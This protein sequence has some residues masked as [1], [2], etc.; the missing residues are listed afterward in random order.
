MAKIVAVQRELEN[1]RKELSS[2]GYIVVDLKEGCSA[3]VI[4]YIWQDE[5]IPYMGIG[6]SL[7]IGLETGKGALLVNARDKS[8]EEIERIIE[9]KLYS[10]LF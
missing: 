7:N 2:L 1:I 5:K 3:D 6:L 4:V 8:I 9:N 10:P